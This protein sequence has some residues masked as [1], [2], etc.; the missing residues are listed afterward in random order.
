M[1][2][3]LLLVLITTSYCSHNVYNNFLVSTLS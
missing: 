1:L 3:L 2:L